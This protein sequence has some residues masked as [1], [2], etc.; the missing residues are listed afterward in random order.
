MNTKFEKAPLYAKVEMALAAEIGTRGLPSGSQ[1]PPEGPLM[2]RFGVSRI[3]L[4]KA[5]ENLAARGLVEIRRGKGT[6]V[7]EPKVTQELSALTGFVEDMVALGRHP[8]ARLL[9]KRSVL[10]TKEVAQHLGIA[11]GTQ[12]YRIER[13]RLAD[14]VAMSFDETYLPLDIGEKVASDDL[15]A[16]P[17]FDLLENKY[18]LP[19]VEAE[20]QLEAATADEHVAQALG[21]EVGSPVFLIER[22]SYTEGHRPIDYEKLH[23]R[24]DLIRFST[25][26]ARRPPTRI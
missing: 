5:I 8:T 17:I 3:T 15:E 2:E 24:G 23:Y 10:A 21:I 11:F 6:F 26:L 19:L 18:E 4:R 7:S 9:D 16:E 22:T 1:L 14:G 25:R 12:V 20:Y 13:V